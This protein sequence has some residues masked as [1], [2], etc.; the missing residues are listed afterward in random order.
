M[1]S[2]SWCGGPRCLEPCRRGLDRGRRPRAGVPH[3]ESWPR[4]VATGAARRPSLSP[5]S[6]DRGRPADPAMRARV[7]RLGAHRQHERPCSDRGW[8]GDGRQIDQ[9]N[10]TL[11]LGTVVAEAAAW[12]RMAQPIGAK[13]ATAAT[14][15]R[16][17]RVCRS[18]S[19][20]SSF[21]PHAEK[22]FAVGCPLALTLPYA[23]HAVEPPPAPP[24]LRSEQRLSRPDS[25]CRC[26]CSRRS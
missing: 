18:T 12:V 3:Q 9:V 15:A 21:V 24:I 13:A 17:R 1:A 22:W 20:V 2:R 4:R 8:Q 10:S 16:F 7:C 26:P 6:A 25:G 23:V 11:S 14:M 5:I 19:P